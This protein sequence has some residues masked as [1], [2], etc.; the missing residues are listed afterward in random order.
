MSRIYVRVRDGLCFVFFA[1]S[2]PPL[3]FCFRFG[4]FVYFCVSF[5]FSML[6]GGLLFLNFHFLFLVFLFLSNTTHPP[7]LL[8]TH[9]GRVFLYIHTY[10]HT[11]TIFFT[12]QVPNQ[13]LN[14]IFSSSSSSSHYSSFQKINQFQTDHSPLL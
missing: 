14:Q 9:R 8:P 12:S 4:S 3:V 13:K 5:C 10:T 6:V 1:F 7:C 11:N 2:L